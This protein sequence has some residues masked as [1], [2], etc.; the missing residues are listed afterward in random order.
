M[1]GGSNEQMPIHDRLGPVITVSHAYRWRRIYS[2]T[3]VLLLLLRR[4]LIDPERRRLSSRNR[5]LNLAAVNPRRDA[6][7]ETCE[8]FG[9]VRPR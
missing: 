7:R 9:N 6:E 8:S 5:V 3:A 2:L 4:L 1:S